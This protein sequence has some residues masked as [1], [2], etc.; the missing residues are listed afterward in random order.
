MI[1]TLNALFNDA[2]IISAIIDRVN[3]TEKDIIYWKKYLQFEQTKSRLFKTYLGTIT[4]VTMGSVIDR[5]S[6]KPIRERKTLGSGVGEVAFMGNAYQLD[7][8]RLDTLNELISKFNG[9]G[10]GQGA[11]MNEI[12]NYLADDIRQVTLAPHKRMDY[13]VG[14]LRSTG[15]ATVKIGDNAQGIEMID[16]ELPVIH[17][18][19]AVGNKD[20]II[21]YIKEKVEELRSTVGTFAVMEM[22]RKTFNSRIVNT[23]SFTNAYKMILGSSEIAVAGGLITDVMANQLLV[24]IGLPTIRI[25]EEYVVKEDGTSINTFADDRIAL[26]PSDNLGKMMF[27]TPYEITDPI[28]SKSYSNLEGG[29]FISTQRTEE[30]RFIEF[31]AEWIPNLKNPNKIAIIDTSLLV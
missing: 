21:D 9:A 8:D 31:G 16:M 11:V 22:N 6:G 2:G 20:T 4:G 13:V 24:G 28:P 7:N 18:K 26:L 10:N 23:S 30:G 29:H 15:K 27:H 3:Q 19:P 12:I 17:Y 25:V 5:N 14:Q 1:L